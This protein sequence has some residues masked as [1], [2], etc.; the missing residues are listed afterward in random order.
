MAIIPATTIMG[1]AM[2]NR[3]QSQSAV[4]DASAILPLFAWLSPSYPVGCYAYSHTLEWAV[5][6]GD[7]TNEQSLIAWLAD[8]LTLGL[9]RNDAILLSHA[10]RAVLAG[11]VAA[12]AE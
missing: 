8:L 6:S 11:D 3:M 12:L 9:G 10:H 1:M 4:H 7:V 2:D 5:E